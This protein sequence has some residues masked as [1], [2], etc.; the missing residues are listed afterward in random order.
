MAEF[1][2]GRL[3]FVWKGAWTPSTLYYVDDVVKF[4]GRT[5][6]CVKGHTSAADYTST[7]DLPVTEWN[8]M[9]DGQSWKGSWSQSTKYQINDLV[10]YGGATYICTENHLSQTTLEEN[11]SSWNVFVT[12]VEWKG[13]WAPSIHYKKYDLV[14]VGGRN[15]ISTEF[16]TSQSTFELDLS[17][18]AVYSSG[19]N[20]V[21]EWEPTKHYNVD[22]VVRF[23]TSTWVCSVT[24]TSS[25]QFTNDQIKWSYLVKGLEFKLNWD[26]QAQYTAGDIVVYGGNQYIATGTST[27]SIPSQEIK[28]NLFSEGFSHEGEF[29][30]TTQYRIG[31]VVKRGSITYRAETDITPISVTVTSVNTSSNSL[32]VS[33]SVGITTNLAVKFN[34][35]VGPIVSNAIY[36]VKDILNVNEFTISTTQGGPA[37]SLAGVTGPL[38]GTITALPPHL[39]FWKVLSSGFVHKGNWAANTQYAEGDVVSVSVGNSV[40]SFV[41]LQS[42]RSTSTPEVNQFWHVVAIGNESSVMTQVGDIV[43]Q[44]ESGPERL[45][46][47]IEGQVLQVDENLKPSWK[48]LGSTPDVYYVS[49][50]GTDAPAPQNGSN[51]DRPW[52][53]I[54]YACRAISNGSKNTTEATLIRRNTVFVLQEVL[55]WVNSKI[56]SNTAPFTNS[57]TYNQEILLHNVGKLVNAIVYD[58][59]HGG[60]S[61]T[62]DVVEGFVSSIPLSYLFSSS[63]SAAS[64]KQCNI[65]I[66][67]FI[68]GLVS[69]IATNEPVIALQSAVQQVLNL[70][71]PGGNRAVVEVLFDVVTVGITDG[72]VNSIPYAKENSATIFV[73]TG[74]YREL[75]PIT[76][77]SNVAVIGDSQYTTTVEPAQPIISLSDAQYTSFIVSQLKDIISPIVQGFSV[78][79]LPGVVASQVTDRVVVPLSTATEIQDVVATIEQYALHLINNTP[80]PIVYG[81]NNFTP[82]SMIQYGVDLIQENE[83]FIKETLQRRLV[84]AYPSSEGVLTLHQ[85]GS[86]IDQLLKSLTTDLLFQSNYRS[87]NTLKTHFHKVFGVLST[88]VFSLNSGS[89]VE[90]LSVNGLTGTL[91]NDEVVSSSYFGLNSGYSSSDSTSFITE[92]PVVKDVV[93][94]GARCVCI[95]SNGNLHAG[96][97]K[98][99]KVMSVQS[100]IVDGVGLHALNGGVIEAD[101]FSS[102]FAHASVYAESGGIVRSEN[103]TSSYGTYGAVS[104][105][106]HPS[107]TPISAVVSYSSGHAEVGVIQTDN[108]SKIVNFEFRTCGRDYTAAE[109]AFNAGSGAIAEF[110]TRDHGIQ[111]VLV[112]KDPV[113]TGY[114]FASGLARSGSPTSIQLSADDT[115][116]SSVYVGMKIS[117]VS[118]SGTGQYGIISSYNAGTKIAQVLNEHTSAPGWSHAVVGTPVVAPDASS[119]YKIEPSVTVTSPE[120]T[121][122]AQSLPLDELWRSVV[123][124]RHTKS[125][126]S[127]TPS[128]GAGSAATFDVVI[129]GRK[130]HVNL[131]N[132]GTGYQK[133]DKLVINKT[134][135][136]NQVEDAIEIIVSSVT[137]N[138]SIQTFET[139]RISTLGGN[140]VAIANNTD[141]CGVSVDG[142]NWT[143]GGLL[144][145]EV[146]WHVAAFHY[147]TIPTLSTQ[148]V[149][150]KIYQIATVGTSLF[151]QVGANSNQVGE[152][153]VASGPIAGTGTALQI[154]SNI[155]VVQENA[156]VTAI[157]SNGGESWTTG[158]ALPF[159]SNI[160]SISSGNGYTL[161]LSSSGNVARTSDGGSS[162]ESVGALPNTTQWNSICYGAGKWVAVSQTSNVV[163]HSTNNGVSWSTSTMPAS[164]SWTAVTFGNNRFVAIS[165]TTAAYSHDGITWYTST[166]PSA[167]WTDLKYSQGI[168]IAVSQSNQSITSENGVY[169]AQR[170]LPDAGGYRS[171]AFGNPFGTPIWAATQYGVVGRTACSIETGATAVLRAVVN[172][173]SVTEFLIIEPGSGYKSEPTVTITDSNVVVPCS[174]TSILNTGVLANPSFVSRGTGITLQTTISG[175]GNGGKV[176]QGTKLIVSQLSNTPVRGSN[177]VIN[178]INSVYTISNVV[179]RDNTVELTLLSQLPDTVIAENTVIGIYNDYSVVYLNSHSFM[180]VGAGNTLSSVSNVDNEVVEKHGGRVFAVSANQDGEFTVGNLLKVSQHTGH[181]QLNA[182]AYGVSNL[183]ELS[184]TSIKLG[185]SNVV[186]TEFSSDPTFAANSNSIV[187]TQSAIRQFV[188]N[189]VNN[190]AVNVTTATV[191][192]ISLQS[193]SISTVTNQPL[194][195]NSPV[196]FNGSVSGF[197]TALGYYL[198]SK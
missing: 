3:K 198:C 98:T 102:N 181:M 116:P 115:Q 8:L 132:A 147:G 76:V 27:N 173:S 99:I 61:K 23:G 70:S 78:T 2:L 142:K 41:C 182:T 63:L 82:N 37:V 65:E 47:G 40:S 141:N 29:N 190:A 69:K 112:E 104:S 56:T 30:F 25:A 154:V 46:I 171:I 143:Q 97:L 31:D 73:K 60:N 111:Q 170:T 183:D 74:T 127:I 13:A 15:Y 180:F 71:T 151:T 81:S 162:W 110:E 32:V 64:N 117:I 11:I 100:N 77:P 189:A 126:V 83:K 122:L 194:V 14:K 33:S 144:P 169:W 193:N 21:G 149:P 153:F 36:Y 54:E 108:N 49:P 51:L 35:S 152:V 5:Y 118:G 133:L 10:Q 134:S 161:V 188:L 185:N 120:F 16:H 136:N 95:R 135:V 165:T 66:I 42:H 168:F 67:A 137:S 192:N 19:F 167:Q 160:R 157:S 139:N 187:P 159:S 113:N 178:G 58:V 93:A 91:S 123:Y 92:P 79:V 34:S 145:S 129:V 124:A 176:P 179:V 174:V 44:G 131:R 6:I 94:K 57:T 9:S 90:K 18:W 85:Y 177:L 26:S 43:Y 186:I 148:L 119:S 84:V 55:S 22:D 172:N 48:T 50:T 106:V 184:L 88:T 52:K 166:I 75:L 72:N 7:A 164:A 38:Q 138:G 114:M 17:K 150:G 121:T 109:F 45:P 125:F 80:A 86:F 128:G 197:P 1:K 39:A 140:F 107:E 4:G 68:K 105:G 59:S 53:T 196:V 89:W 103:G 163:A 146:D 175:N 158:G 28:W 62:Y 96:G 87:V 195:F 12:G 130:A 24:H 191:G 20:F 101:D 156:A 155:I